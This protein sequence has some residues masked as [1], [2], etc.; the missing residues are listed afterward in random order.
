MSTAQKV[1][2]I[3]DSFKLEE[4]SATSVTLRDSILTKYNEKIFDYL[5]Y[6]SLDSVRVRVDSVI[7]KGLTITTKF[8]YDQDIAFQYGLTFLKDMSAKH[9][10]LFQFMKGLP[11]GSD[12]TVNFTY[13]ASHELN[14][15]P[16]TSSP[17]L[18]IFAIPEPVFPIKH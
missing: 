1:Q 11:I 9:E 17:T 8:H 6:H 12:T 5:S 4:S 2:T 15:K 16:D 18:I 3:I 10:A 7:V 14:S 13:M